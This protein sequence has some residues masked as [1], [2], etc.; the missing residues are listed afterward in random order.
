MSTHPFLSLH[1]VARLYARIL[2][3]H[4]PTPPESL[5]KPSR[6]ATVEE[7]LGHTS[8]FAS[9]SELVRRKRNPGWEV[10][11]QAFELTFKEALKLLKEGMDPYDEARIARGEQG[12]IR[13]KGKWTVNP[14]FP[15]D[16]AQQ[17]FGWEGFMR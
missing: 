4:S 13:G 3:C 14:D 16:V 11:K 2:L 10:E 9:I 15:R 8:A 5:I 7:T 6:P 17:L 1:S 12:G